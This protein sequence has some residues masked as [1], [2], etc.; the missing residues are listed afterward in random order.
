MCYTVPCAIHVLTLLAICFKYSRV[1]LIILES[2]V[3]AFLSLLSL[4]PAVFTYG[5]LFPCVFYGFCRECSFSFIFN[6]VGFFEV[7]NNFEFLSREFTLASESHLRGPFILRPE[8]VC[9]QFRA[10]CRKQK[11]LTAF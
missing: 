10:Q 5:A 6:F 9:D 3:L 4:V 1:S 8:C 11:L 2:Q 7:Q